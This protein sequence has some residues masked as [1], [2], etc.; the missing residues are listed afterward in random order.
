MVFLFRVGLLAALYHYNNEV[1]ITQKAFSFAHSSW[2][3]ILW[4]ESMLLGP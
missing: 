2:D 3:L 1:D 4:L